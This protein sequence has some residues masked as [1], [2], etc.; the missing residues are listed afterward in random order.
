MMTTFRSPTS[1]FFGDYTLSG[2]M[3]VL[4]LASYAPSPAW[5]YKCGFLL[6]GISSRTEKRVTTSSF[7]L[8]AEFSAVSF[9]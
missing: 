2:C 8:T 9:V 1:S 5:S 3:L 4:S 7:A 6:D